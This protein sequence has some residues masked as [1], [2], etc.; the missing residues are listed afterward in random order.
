M[1]TTR[2]VLCSYNPLCFQGSRHVNVGHNDGREDDDNPKRHATHTYVYC[3]TI[4][5]L[6]LYLLVIRCLPPTIRRRRYVHIYIYIVNRMHMATPSR[7]RD[8]AYLNVFFM[9]D[10]D[11]RHCCVRKPCFVSLLIF[12]FFIFR[13]NTTPQYARVCACRVIYIYSAHRP[14]RRLLFGYIYIYIYYFKTYTRITNN[15]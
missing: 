14:N 7:L 10:K 15:S 4:I 13:L 3:L 8:C 11:R 6:L 2:V 12:L 9:F 5:L 1:T